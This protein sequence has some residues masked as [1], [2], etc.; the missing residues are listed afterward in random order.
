MHLRQI[1]AGNGEPDRVRAG[2]EQQRAVTVPA[3]VREPDLAG[4]GIDRR[5]AGA[6]LQLDPVLAVE[7]GRT[8]RYPFLGR[9]AGEIVL[10]QIGPVV[11]PA[12][13]RRSAS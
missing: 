5:R 1:A 12:P 4:L 9:G 6:E 10:G 3:A 7:F 8:Q 13:R 2:G 11:R